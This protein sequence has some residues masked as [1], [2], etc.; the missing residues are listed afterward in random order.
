MP[1]IKSAKKALRQ[2]KRKQERNVVYKT[3]I[4]K[5]KKNIEKVLATKEIE[6]AKTDL[7]SFYKIV[8]KAAK[9]N[10]IHKNKANRIKSRLALKIK[11]TK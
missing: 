1:I 3:G 7:S 4:K 10:V 8:D 2:S 6:K 11:N 5:T 9:R